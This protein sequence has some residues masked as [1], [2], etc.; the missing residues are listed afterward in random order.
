MGENLVVTLAPSFLI[1]SSSFLQV[2]RTTIKSRL[3]SKFS[4]IRSWTTEIT[5]R[6]PLE[7]NPNTLVMGEMLRPL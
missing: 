1:E 7:K 6:E 3:S 4:Q 2:T 5:A